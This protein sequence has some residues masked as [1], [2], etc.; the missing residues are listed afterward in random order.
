[1]PA[2]TIDVND[3]LLMRTPGIL[4]AVVRLMK[5]ISTLRPT[6]I[7]ILHLRWLLLPPALSHRGLGPM[8]TTSTG[9]LLH[10]SC[11]NMDRM[12]SE[13]SSHMLPVLRVSGLRRRIARPRSC[14][15]QSRHSRCRRH[16]RPPRGASS[17]SPGRGLSGLAAGPAS[18]CIEAERSPAA[19]R[20]SRDTPAQRPSSCRQH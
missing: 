4:L 17:A 12:T 18:V 13:L 10:A 15:S 6:A 14:K 8:K 5:K 2:V 11:M 3:H 16:T 1:M 19:T 20:G 7:R 9:F